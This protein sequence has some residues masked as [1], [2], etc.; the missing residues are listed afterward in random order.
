MSFAERS[1]QTLNVL[2]RTGQ[3]VSLFPFA[4]AYE[5]FGVGKYTAWHFL[6]IY[7]AWA[8]FYGL[9]ALAGRLA[10]SF[11]A[12]RRHSKRLVPIMNFLSKM[13]FILPTAG[14]IAAGIALKMPEAVYYYILTAA[15]ISYF[16]GVLGVGRS[17]ADIFSLGWCI[18]YLAAGTCAAVA[19]GTLESKELAESGSVMLC[20][21][22]A[23]V[24][25]LSA[26][27][28][29]QSNID[30]CTNRRDHGKAVLPRG[31]RSYN[32]ALGGGIFAAAL[33]LFLFAKPLGRLIG[34]FV[35][36][37]IR[38]FLSVLSL[39]SSCA[40]I[41]EE[42]PPRE[43]DNTEHIEPLPVIMTNNS[44]EDIVT[45]VI[46]VMLLVAATAFR[47]QIWNAL[48]SLLEPL[49]RTRD[50]TND[51]PFADEITESSEKR[52]LT[53]SSERKAEREL[54]RRYARERSPKRKYRLGY[55]LFLLR[56][57]RTEKPPK[58]YDTTDEHRKKGESVFKEELGEL[59]RV[60]NKVRYAEYTPSARELEAESELLKKLG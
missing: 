60:Y 50:K 2:A 3:L 53:R 11:A 17:Y 55:A 34:A 37:L 52:K 16:G 8:V 30:K 36:L 18:L 49:F 31:L 13:G 12:R 42:E 59:T 20:A 41:P 29:N 44:T 14:F 28:K 4:V 54:M 23:V 40:P 21:A 46:V 43:I 15:V 19:F 48:K 10:E 22:F 9:G 58:R 47:K 57:S 27:L 26:A 6:A 56:L 25:L 35:G 39:L 45:A 5:A 51:I 24:I 38:A 1:G 32:A 7:A 33:G